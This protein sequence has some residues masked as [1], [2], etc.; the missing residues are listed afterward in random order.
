[1][2]RANAERLTISSL[3]DEQEKLCAD[4]VMPKFA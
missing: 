4:P 1:M 3:L 2:R